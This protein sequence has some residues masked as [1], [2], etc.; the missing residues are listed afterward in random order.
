MYAQELIQSYEAGERDFK[1]VVLDDEDLSGQ[2]LN[3]IDLEGASLAR[4][5]FDETCLSGANL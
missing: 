3:G 1:G 4:V 2:D 5:T